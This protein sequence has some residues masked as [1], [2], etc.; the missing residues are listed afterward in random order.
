MLRIE[1]LHCHPILQSIDLTLPDRGLVGLAGANGSGKTT[2][3]KCLGGIIRQFK[4][5]VYWHDRPLHRLRQPELA[6]Y[7]AYVPQLVETVIPYTV[8]ELLRLSRYPYLGLARNGPEP[9]DP[10]SVLEQV[11]C[12]PL[13]DRVV[14]TL[15]GGELQKV[16]L[17]A[18]LA[19]QTPI[20]LLDEPASH[21]DPVRSEELGRLLRTLADTGDRLLI[22]VSH[23]PAHLALCDRVVALKAGR[24]LDAGGPELLTDPRWLDRV[25]RTG[26]RL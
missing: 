14:S 12:K 26:D 11:Q 5:G 2:L 1:A 25:Y 16:L 4:G 23:Q 21:L 9:P 13:R 10:D 20:V 19:Q 3:L 6:R 15:S 24:V 18:A 17:A 22:M 7:V 8:R